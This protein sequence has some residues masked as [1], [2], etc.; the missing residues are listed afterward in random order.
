M[1]YL[2]Y[3]KAFWLYFII[4]FLGAGCQKDGVQPME[5]EGVLTGGST[6]IHSTGP[7]AFTFPLANLN[8]T[9][10]QKHLQ[11]DGAFAQQFV[12]A[13]ATQFGGLGPLFNQNSCESCHIRNGRGQVPRFEGDTK[14]GLLLRLSVPGTG[15][16]GEIL[17]APGFGGQ[18]QTKAI[19]GTEP[20]GKLSWTEQM[21]IVTFVDGTSK[22]ISKRIYSVEEPYTALPGGLM[23]SP[24]NAP[25]VYGLGLLEAIK[26]ED[27]LKNADEQDLNGDGIS[28]KPNWVW[29][30]LEEK[31][32]LGRFGWKA[33]NPTAAQQSADAAHNDMGLTSFYFKN[34][35]C[36][37]QS[38]CQDGLSPGDDVDGETIDLFTFYF[39]ALAVPAARGLD[40]PDVKRGKEL[41]EK[42][43]CTACHTPSFKT[44]NHPMSELSN[45]TIFP[46]TDMLLHD[47]G[48]G[49]ADNR[50]EFD[51]NGREWRTAPLWGIGLNQI[52]NPN[53]TFLHDGRAADLEEAILW[54]GGEAEKSR[55]VFKKF[56]KEEKML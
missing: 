25:P 29:E 11:A 56:S 54:H 34:E 33:G 17:P 19:F 8:A 24:R 16:H 31:K 28:G 7:D 22:E 1:R 52:V 43:N 39:Q 40:L 50:P 45:Q 3:K 53:T 21:E 48:E 10:L 15:P 35:S 6:T 55:D 2:S 37:G 20:E 51:A 9:G 30:V 49:L 41:F 12:T 4:W 5:L 27:I 23:I 26:E 18:L 13:P 14:S 38:N 46:Y 47:M 42:A 32:S 44:G 36:E